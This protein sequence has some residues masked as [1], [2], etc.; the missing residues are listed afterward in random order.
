MSEV[1]WCFF[2]VL[3]FL[4]KFMNFLLI[5]NLKNSRKLKKYIPGVY[6]KLFLRKVPENFIKL[7]KYPIFLGNSVKFKNLKL[8]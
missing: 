2:I 5:L 4:K 1:R 3:N 7:K 6:R 8:F